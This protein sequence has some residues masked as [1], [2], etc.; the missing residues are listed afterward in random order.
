M[1][2]KTKAKP[3]KHKPDW[4][5]MFADRIINLENRMDAVERTQAKINAAIMPKEE[6]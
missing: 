4:P 1:K 2:K 6:T 3:K 5:L